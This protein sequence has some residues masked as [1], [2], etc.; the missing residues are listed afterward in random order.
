MEY[1]MSILSL[2]DSIKDYGSNSSAHN[3]NVEITFTVPS[4]YFVLFFSANV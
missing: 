1:N 4:D 2:T 3:Q